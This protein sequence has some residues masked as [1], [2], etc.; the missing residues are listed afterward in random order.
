VLDLSVA[1]G[2][3]SIAAF[4][5]QED[6]CLATQQ[7]HDA[8]GGPPL[9]TTLYL[10]RHAKSSWADP[11]AEDHDRPLQEKGRLRAANLVAWLEERALGCDLVLCSTAARTRETLDIVRP[12]LGNPEVRYLAEI[13]GAGTDDLVG[14]L[15]SIDED[16]ERVMVVGHDPTLQQTALALSMTANG[17]ARERLSRKYPTSALALLTFGSAGW[18]SLTPGMGHLEFF[19]VPPDGPQG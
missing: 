2:C 8:E 6:C 15:K 1:E 11:E 14:L 7:P 9:P 10:L 5:R 13:Y 4:R 17:D 18:P 3:F 19:Y 12:A 16:T